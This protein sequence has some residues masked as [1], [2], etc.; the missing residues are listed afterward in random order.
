MKDIYC[1]IPA[2]AGSKRIIKKNIKT[3]NGKPLIWWTVNAA[4]K[5]NL[6][7][8]IIVSSDDNDIIDLAR[9]LN[10]KAF[11]RSE[12]VDDLSTSSQATIFT[13]KKSS[14]ILKNDTV[15]FQLLPTCPLRT[16]LDLIKAYQI[17]NKKELISG[18]SGFKM[19]FGTPHWLMKNTSNKIEFLFPDKL[20]KRSQD[21]DTLY[22]LSGCVWI[23][24]YGYLLE[25][26]SFKGDKTGLLNLSWLSCLDIDTKEEFRIVEKL[27]SLVY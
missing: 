16:N 12:Y 26:N 21:L 27:A 22:L 8:E 1:I 23:S 13:L 24:Q 17:Y 3:F 14:L 19:C 2:R 9:N 15:I 4:I 20:E 6:F 10:V 11:K 25:N 7:T 5:S 18:I